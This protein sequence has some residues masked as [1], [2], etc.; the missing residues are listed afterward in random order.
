[1]RGSTRHAARECAWLPNGRGGSTSHAD[2][3]GQLLPLGPPPIRRIGLARCPVGPDNRGMATA[4]PLT[5][6]QAWLDRARQ[7]I[8]LASQTFSKAPN[9]FVRGASPVFLAR[10]QGSHVWDVDDNE[11]IDYPTAL[12]PII[13]G[14]NDPDVTAAVSAQLARGTIFSLPSPLEVEVA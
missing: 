11:F 9:Q 6:S 14:Y 12:G 13:L 2:D 1:Q 7:V 3:G 8:P 4:L 10:G 5:S